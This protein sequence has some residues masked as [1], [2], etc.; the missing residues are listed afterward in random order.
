MFTSVTEENINDLIASLEKIGF[1]NYEVVI[2]A[3]E[4]AFKTPQQPGKKRKKK[5]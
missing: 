1:A 4:T 3:T 5:L 2:E